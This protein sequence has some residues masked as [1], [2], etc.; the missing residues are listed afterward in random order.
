M[1]SQVE[2]SMKSQVETSMKSQVET[3][4]KSSVVLFA[5]VW[6]Y[7]IIR[8]CME[9]FDEIFSCIIRKCME[10]LYYSQVYGKL[11]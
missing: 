4:M 9:N 11:R 3:S 6:K 1:K 7:C 10:I 8:K 2:T 5:S